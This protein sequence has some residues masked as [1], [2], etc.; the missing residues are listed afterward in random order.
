MEY[1]Y[2]FTLSLKTI[3]KYLY[4]GCQTFE[5]PNR[6][7]TCKFHKGGPKIRTLVVRRAPTGNVMVIQKVKKNCASICL[8]FFSSIRP[9]LEA[10]KMLFPKLHFSS[11]FSPLWATI[12]SSNRPWV[13]AIL[14]LFTTLTKSLEKRSRMKFDASNAVYKRFETVI[15]AALALKKIIIWTDDGPSWQFWLQCSWKHH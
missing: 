10:V 7:S 1:R 2:I 15:E 5:C 6:Y 12:S 11:D 8:I 14:L 4:I 13:F 3:V 9:L